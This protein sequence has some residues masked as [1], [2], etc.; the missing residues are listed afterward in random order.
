MSLYQ[1]EECGCI[2]N[3]ACGWYHYRKHSD[4]KYGDRKLCS[5][6]GPTKFDDGGSTELGEWHGRFKREF[7]ELGT[8]ETDEVGNVRPKRKPKERV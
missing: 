3:T 7:H 2:E 4:P 1:C 5:V 6:C 8:M